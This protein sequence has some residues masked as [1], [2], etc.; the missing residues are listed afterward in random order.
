MQESTR[1]SEI[2]L[3]RHVHFERSLMHFRSKLQRPPKK[4]IKVIKKLQVILKSIYVTLH[5]KSKPFVSFFDKEIKVFN[6]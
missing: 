3:N 2:E 4:Y 5:D 1:M 6:D